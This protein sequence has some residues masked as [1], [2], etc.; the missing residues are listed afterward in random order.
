MKSTLTILTGFRNNITYLKE[1]YFTTP[2]KVADV[3]EDKTSALLQL[4]L[5]SSSPGVLN[6]DTYNILVDV[7]DNAS[8]WLHTQS[9][10]RLF[11]MKDEANQRTVFNIG[12]NASFTYLPHPTVPHEC[13]SFTSHNRFNLSLGSRLIFAEILTAGRGLNKE[14]F[15]LNR[16]HTITDVY[17]NSKLILKE[18]LLVQPSTTSPLAIGQME[19]YTHQASMIIINPCIKPEEITGTLYNLLVAE[20]Q[21]EPGVTIG[22]NHTVVVRILGYKAELLHDL[23]KQCAKAVTDLEKINNTSYAG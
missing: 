6:G 16:Y 22:P 15:T 10:Q 9:Y 17:I 11:T 21:V 5:M 19:Q 18:N 8:L 23:V 20:K 4:M 2:L 13:S 7:A 3:T 1:A 14:Q 12:A